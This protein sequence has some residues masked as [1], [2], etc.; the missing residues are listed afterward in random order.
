VS[1]SALEL[2]ID[3]GELDATVHLGVPDTASAQWQQAGR[4]GRRAGGASLAV[5]VATER[6]LDLYYLA[7]PEALSRRLSEATHVDPCNRALMEMHLAAAAD[8]LPLVAED[9]EF[10]GGLENYAGGLQGAVNAHAI[11]Y[12]PGIRSYRC[13]MESAAFKISLRG[14][15]SRDKWELHDSA[16]LNT[17]GQPCPESL[18]E[19]VDSARAYYKVH[20]GALFHHRERV[21]EVTRL[22]ATLKLALGRQVN[23][24]P[25]V[26]AAR[27]KCTVLEVRTQATK[28]V[29]ASHAWLGRL[30]VTTLV[31]GFVKQNQMKGEN[32]FEKTFPPPGFNALDLETDGVWFSLPRELVDRLAPTGA[33]KEAVLGVRNLVLALV[34]SVAAC[35]PG[36]IGA[37]VVFPSDSNAEGATSSS[38]KLYVFDSF[39]GVGLCSKIYDNLEPLWAQC[40]AVLDRC[41]CSTGCASCSQAGR[42]GKESGEAKKECRVVLQGLLGAWMTGGKASS[43]PLSRT[44][45][46]GAASGG[47]GS[48][49]TGGGNAAA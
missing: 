43:L 39:G 49:R 19:T 32:V 21:Y 40:L 48:A 28:P 18:V 44:T 8:E 45:G 16:L 31:T 47:G 25:F 5:V 15:T 42:S 20:E 2:G 30:H 26:T 34:P 38:A 36:D 6:P 12:D 17:S 27:D 29:A 37:A 14:S 24:T 35:E 4:A 9:A 3:V 22:D 46:G 41:G 11:A 33:L 13:C 7:N 23:D 1:T 10:F